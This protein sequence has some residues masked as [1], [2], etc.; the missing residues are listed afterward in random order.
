M[1]TSRDLWKLSGRIWNLHTHLPPLLLHPQSTPSVL[2]RAPAARRVSFPSKRRSREVL[3]WLTQAT[4]SGYLLLP[5][6]LPTRASGSTAM[7]TRQPCVSISSLK[8]DSTDSV[9]VVSLPQYKHND[10]CFFA[11]AN[12][13]HAVRTQLISRRPWA[14]QLLQRVIHP[15]RYLPRSERSPSLASSK[16]SLKHTSRQLFSLISAALTFHWP[17]YR[18]SLDHQEV[19]TNALHA[20]IPVPTYRSDADA[21]CSSSA[22]RADFAL[23]AKDTSRVMSRPTPLYTGL[24]QVWSCAGHLW[25]PGKR[26]PDTA[27]WNHTQLCHS[28]GSHYKTFIA[29]I[30]EAKWQMTPVKSLQSGPKSSTTPFCVN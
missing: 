14:A 9:T 28:K 10:N 25:R 18:T 27:A 7:K 3:L 23:S 13:S 20:T 17:S 30:R 21:S 1:L 6:R 22:P 26:N 19:H 11:T 4:R 2:N 5:R 15:W 24:E 16:P 12:R 29:P 8:P